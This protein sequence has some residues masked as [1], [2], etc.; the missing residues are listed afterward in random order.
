MNSNLKLKLH[1][2]AH[3]MTQS[4]HLTA[5]T[6]KSR[7]WNWNKVLLEFYDMYGISRLVATWI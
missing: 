1:Q 4:K 5:M 6:L 3:T 7:K 2:T